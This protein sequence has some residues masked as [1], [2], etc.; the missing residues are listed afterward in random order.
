MSPEP[1]PA[2]ADAEREPFGGLPA[3]L[4]PRTDELPGSGRMRLVETTLLVLVGIVLLVATVN[5]LARQ[6]GVNYRLIADLRTWRQYTGHAYKNL[7][8][9]QELLGVSTKHEV[10]CGNTSPGPPK[11]RIQLCLVMWGPVIDGRRTV[12]GGWYLPPGSEDQ[13]SDRY[14]CF[15]E[16]ARG[17][18]PR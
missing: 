1:A 14:G 7:S 18:C 16:A 17:V 13:R 10:V 12:R 11:A 4:R 6:T 5:D 15:G 3:W 9:D 2:P 8:V